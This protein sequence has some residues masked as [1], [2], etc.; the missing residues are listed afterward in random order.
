[1]N[2]FFDDLRDPPNSSWVVCRDPEQLKDMLI[3]K[4]VDNLS[5]DHDLGY[6]TESGKEITGYDILCWMEQTNHLPKGRIF[7]HSSNP[8]G[9]MRMLTV[10][11]LLGK[12]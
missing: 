6:Y 1:M 7:V 4:M 2:V 11:K 10:I 8:V 3:C 12:L 5:L 9:K